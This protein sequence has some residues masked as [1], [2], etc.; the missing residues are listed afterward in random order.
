MPKSPSKWWNDIKACSFVCSAVPL[1]VCKFETSSLLHLAILQSSSSKQQHQQ[2]QQTCRALTPHHISRTCVVHVY[3]REIPAFSKIIIN[4]L[5]LRGHCVPSAHTSH[6]IS[7]QR[8]NENKKAKW[9]EQSREKKK[10]QQQNA[11]HTSR[12][13]IVLDWSAAK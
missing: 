11:M 4:T 3:Y 9:N 6:L 2:H 1:H 5:A 12:W 8:K 10:M 13:K 7:K